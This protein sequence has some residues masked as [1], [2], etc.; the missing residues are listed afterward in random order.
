MKNKANAPI[1]DD[2]AAIEAAAQLAETPP[3]EERVLDLSLRPRSLG[4][5]VGQE[6][7]K[8]ILGMSIEAARMRKEVMDHVLFSGPPGLGKTSL[9]HIIARELGV[10]LRATSGPAIERAGDLA[11][12]VADLDQGDVLFVDE[13]HRLA[14]PVEEILYPAMEDF[15]LNIVVGK[16]PGA[17]SMRLAV[18]PFTMVGA[19]TRSGLLSS[20]LRDRFGQHFHLDFYA[21]EELAEIVRRSARLL[22]IRLTNEGAE[23][24]AARSRGTP[25]IVNRLLRR[26]RDFAQVNEMPLVTREVALGAL[27]LL[28]IDACGFDRMDRSILAAIIDKFDGGPVGVESLAAA[29]GEEADTIE[30]VYEPYLLQEGFVARTARG[31]MATQRAYSHLGRTRRGTLL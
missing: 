8:K 18:K 30:E 15:E 4:D 16:G 22:G 14:R 21:R 12:I 3:E 10:N 25:R 23:E 9:A 2:G 31:R 7:L 27:E 17:R 29:V 6:R 28:E 5:F 19:T 1:G 20:P 26:V 13:I 11:A 24:A